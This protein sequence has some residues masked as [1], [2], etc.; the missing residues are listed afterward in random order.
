[1]PKQT[2]FLEVWRGLKGYVWS[3]R[4]FTTMLHFKEEYDYHYVFFGKTATVIIGTEDYEITREEALNIATDHVKG[5]VVVVNIDLSICGGLP[6]K[7]R[8]HST[9]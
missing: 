3:E 8:T 4:K 2:I 7:Q 1:M 5:N 6:E 9:P